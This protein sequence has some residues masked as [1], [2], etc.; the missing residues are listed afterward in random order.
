D[1]DFTYAQ[2]LH[3]SIAL[4]GPSTFSEHD[5]ELQIACTAAYNDWLSEF[6]S[7]NPDRLIGLGL[8]PTTGVEDAIAEMR[9]V[10]DLPGMKGVMLGG[11]P[12]G[13]AHP[14]PADDRFWAEAQDMDVPVVIHVGLGSGD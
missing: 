13:G 10:R 11:W 4:L 7:T 5:A 1:T 12:N 14:S 9:R 2:V 8:V 6:C 3:P